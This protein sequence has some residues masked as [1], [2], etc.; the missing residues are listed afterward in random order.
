MLNQT[1][2]KLWQSCDISKYRIVVQIID[3]VSYRDETWDLHPDY[4]A[5]VATGFTISTDWTST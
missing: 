5:N 2:I 1:E 3:I 4:S